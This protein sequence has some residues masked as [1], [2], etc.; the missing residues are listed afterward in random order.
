M[1]K[2]ISLLTACVLLALNAKAQNVPEVTIT[3]DD[4]TPTTITVSFDKNDACL[5]YGCLIADM[6]SICQ[7]LPMYGNDTTRI[8]KE[9]AYDVVNDTTWHWNDMTPG[10]EYTIFAVAYGADDCIIYRTTTTMPTQGDNG[11]SE[12]SISVSNIT[13][14]SATVT[15]TPN[16]STSLF[17]DMLMETQYFNSIGN[18][19]VM[20]MLK[21]DQYT[22]YETDNW[23]WMD[24]T[25]G[26][27]YN[28]CAIGMNLAEEWGP[29]AVTTFTTATAGIATTQDNQLV[30]FPNPTS[31]VINIEGAEFNK[32]ELFDLQGTK[33]MSASG[34]RLDMSQLAN[35]AYLLRI[36]MSGRMI[37]KRIVKK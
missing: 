34:K 25:P 32:A 8:I 28:A 31:G 16:A 22:Y 17:K 1:K 29:L 18:D 30:V 14:T 33:M 4:A 9:W 11:T 3:V 7:W 24:L 13:S 36:D 15:C 6:P 35:G 37:T 26:M 5:H 20:A 27:E 19:S 12:I 23:T 2:I 21:M 10:L